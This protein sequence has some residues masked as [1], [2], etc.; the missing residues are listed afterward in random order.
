[1]VTS[2]E[3][4]TGVSIPKRG[5]QSLSEKICKVGLRESVYNRCLIKKEEAGYKDRSNSEFAEFLL[6]VFNYDRRSG[7]PTASEI[8]SSYND[9][10]K[11]VFYIMFVFVHPCTFVFVFIFVFAE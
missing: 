4:S 2:D 6:E 8:L 11:T 10:G 9:M 1:M 7:S 3:D 5:R